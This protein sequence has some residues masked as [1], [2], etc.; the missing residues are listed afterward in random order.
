M[1]TAHF[2]LKSQPFI[3]S[4]PTDGIQEDVCAAINKLEALKNEI[5]AQRGKKISNEAAN[6]VIAYTD[7]VIAYFLSKLSDG[8]SC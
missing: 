7:S 3:E 5:N 1:F 6:E 2:K 8:E 4:M